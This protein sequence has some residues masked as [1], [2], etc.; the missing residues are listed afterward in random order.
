MYIWQEAGTFWINLHRSSWTT[1]SLDMF[2]SEMTNKKVI[3]ENQAKNIKIE[4]NLICHELT[5]Y[6]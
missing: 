1:F 5:F 4:F 6:W 3:A 2:F